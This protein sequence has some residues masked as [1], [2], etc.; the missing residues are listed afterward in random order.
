MMRY[1]YPLPRRRRNNAHSKNNE[2]TQRAGTNHNA[3]DPG[4]VLYHS[5]QSNVDDEG[6][7][8]CRLETRNLREELPANPLYQ[9]YE[10]NSAVDPLTPLQVK[11][12]I[13]QRVSEN[14][15]YSHSVVDPHTSIQVMEDIYHRVS[16]NVPDNNSV[17]P[18]AKLYQSSNK[19][20]NLVESQN[21]NVY[22]Q[23]SKPK[24][25]KE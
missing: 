21:D 3:N 10:E 1:Y 24:K 5:H 4:D 25:S 17:Y 6:Y 15:Q 14:L 23:V 13:Y 9:S 11:E 2:N 18:C 20:L 16:E 19:E 22:A 8:T 7:S 12:D